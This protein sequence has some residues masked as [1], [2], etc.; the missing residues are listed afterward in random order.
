MIYGLDKNN[1]D[2]LDNTFINK[3]YIKNELLNNT[4]GNI[5]LYEE[6]NEILGYIYYSDI[7]DRV[8]INQ[9]E[10]DLI[11]RN[12]G[13]GKKFL[14]KFIETVDKDITLEVKIDNNPAIKVYEDNDFKRMAIRK[15]YYKGIDGILMERKKDSK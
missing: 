1:L 10:I 5:L 4:F 8:E 11:H 14:K 6:D 15:G 3:E 2:I 9:F 7:Y 13:K 12:C